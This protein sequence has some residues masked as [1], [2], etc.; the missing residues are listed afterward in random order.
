[1]IPLNLVNWGRVATTLALV[2]LLAAGLWK[3]HH[4]GVTSGR[5]EVQAQ[6]KLAK[7]AQ[8]EAD[9]VAEADTRQRERALQDDADNL[10]KAKDEQIKKIDRQL[11]LALAAV[12]VQ[13]ATPRPPDYTPAAAGAGAACSGAS[14]FTQDAEFLVRESARA[15]GIRAAYLNCEA[16]YNKA[17]D[18]MIAAE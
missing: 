18:A 6:W 13:H 14:L 8:A 9:K 3:V 1:M 16:Q 12:R 5:A 10:R 15:D 4:T 11:K 2:A 17:R 7:L